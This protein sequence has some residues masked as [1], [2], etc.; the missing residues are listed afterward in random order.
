MTGASMSTLIRAARDLMTAV[1]DDEVN[2]GGL[3]SRATI[4]R[5]DLL[6]LELQVVEAQGDAPTTDPSPTR[7][8]VPC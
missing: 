3:L 4:R 6:R 5:A 2:H 8:V 7:E 1:I